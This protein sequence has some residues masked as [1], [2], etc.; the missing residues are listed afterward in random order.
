MARAV[1]LIVLVA[2][3]GLAACKDTFEEWRKQVTTAHTL[4][5]HKLTACVYMH[6]L[7]SVV[8][9]YHRKYASEEEYEIRS[10]IFARNLDYIERFNG[11][12]HS[13]KC[14]FSWAYTYN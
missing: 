11:E 3:V 1:A 10:E 7:T 2:L 8:Y 9:Q 14:R 5:L 12:S 4:Q 13:Y 6:E